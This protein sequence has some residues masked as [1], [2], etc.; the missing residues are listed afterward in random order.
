MYGTERIWTK[1]QL[2]ELSKG[3]KFSEFSVKLKV[4]QGEFQTK[5]S[6][7]RR[8]SHSSQTDMTCGNKTVET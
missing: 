3:A 6:D 1:Y 2:K 4:K 7:I 8:S 5:V